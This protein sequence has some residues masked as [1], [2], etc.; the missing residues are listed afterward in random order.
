MREVREWELFLL[1]AE[2]PLAFC[3]LLNCNPQCSVFI[4]Q[5][6]FLFE[7]AESSFPPETGA[8]ESWDR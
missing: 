5:F 4:T 7:R 2:L 3:L 6:Q 8:E 1:A